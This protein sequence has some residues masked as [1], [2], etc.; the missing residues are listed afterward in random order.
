MRKLLR[1]DFIPC[2][3]LTSLFLFLFAAKWNITHRDNVSDRVNDFVHGLFTTASFQ[4]QITKATRTTQQKC[5]AQNLISIKIDRSISLSYICICVFHHFCVWF[6]SSLF[7]YSLNN[8]FKSTHPF[9]FCRTV[10]TQ[11]V[12][13]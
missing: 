1:F 10:S 2:L 3:L 11:F 6:L 12:S 5:D 13:I 9:F 7:P 4:A 8:I